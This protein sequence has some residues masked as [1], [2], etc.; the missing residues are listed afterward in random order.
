MPSATEL[1]LAESTVKNSVGRGVT[2]SQVC[3]FSSSVAFLL[4]LSAV[5]FRVLKIDDN[6]EMMVS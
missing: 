6:M 5:L 3:I 2:W 4:G 1:S